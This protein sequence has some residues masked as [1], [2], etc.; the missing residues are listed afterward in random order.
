MSGIFLS[1]SRGD[2]PLALQIL[3]NLRALGAEVWWDEDMP[4]VDWQEYLA[5]QIN[6][7]D[8]VLVIW[9]PLSTASKNVRDEARLGQN[10]EKLV[11]VM[12][13]VREPPFPFDRVNGL[14]L[15]GW[16]GRQSH[17]G[18][19]RLVKT[20]EERLVANSA[21][22][23][24][25]LSRAFRRREQRIEQRR[26]E[27][28]AAE[29]A[30]AEAQTVNADT[31]EA[32][33]SA[34][35]ECTAAEG[36]LR[37]VIDMQA[38]AMLIKAAQQQLDAA[39]AARTDAEQARHSAAAMLAAASKR[40]S[41]A[42]AELERLFV[43]PA[44]D[45][46]GS[47]SLDAGPPPSSPDS[48]A[49]PAPK[50][51]PRSPDPTS[52]PRPEASPRAEPISTPRPDPSQNAR[53]DPPTTVTKRRVPILVW[54]V[55]GIVVLVALAAL[56]RGN[57][58]PA[59][60]PVESSSAQETDSADGAASSEG[61]ATPSAAATA[62][63]AAAAAISAGDRAA[64]AGDSKTALADYMQAANLGDARAEDVVCRSYYQGPSFSPDLGLSVNYNNAAHWCR[65]AA[66][67]GYSDAEGMMGVFYE[68]GV[69][70]G[71]PRNFAKALYWYRLAAA[72]GDN[73]SQGELDNMYRNGE[74]VPKGTPLPY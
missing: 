3:Q 55:G 74:G 28:S 63:S 52:K 51:E 31:G 49:P 17:S 33:D 22:Q 1:Y 34:R 11:N 24:G 67:Q 10:T 36:Q 38:G 44:P 42:K 66:A 2:R 15:D 12:V 72:Q 70:V 40:L 41:T 39:L 19:S 71:E 23:P 64:S 57:P 20:I 47:P 13:G 61:P 48:V 37:S 45:R 21:A 59:P 14:P 35:A 54:V 43:D 69:G 4:G 26:R 46:T 25:E 56:F 29:A 18:W 65:L 16:T 27:V 32:L 6:E 58:A 30:F 68:E 9:T 50:P 53:P 73:F 7:L 62:P 8:V 5:N 60:A